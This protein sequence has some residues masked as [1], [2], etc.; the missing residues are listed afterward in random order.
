MAINAMCKRICT[1]KYDKD[2]FEWKLRYRSLWDTAFVSFEF[3]I[4]KKTNSLRLDW[5][6]LTAAARTG[7]SLGNDTVIHSDNG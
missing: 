4:K 1:I 6:Y 7:K 3:T 2:D 5:N